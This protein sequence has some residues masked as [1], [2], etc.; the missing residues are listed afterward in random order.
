MAW[1]RPR[2]R[3]TNADPT[4]VA[5]YF[6]QYVELMRHGKDVCDEA[7]KQHVFDIISD[8]G[9]PDRFV[10]TE[11]EPAGLELPAPR[12]NPIIVRRENGNGPD[13]REQETEG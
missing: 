6:R 11:A 7:M 4:A 9:V 12:A 5:F 3:Y 13:E 8:L 2:V 10:E 1:W